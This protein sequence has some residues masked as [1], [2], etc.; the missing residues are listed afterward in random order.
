MLS[1]KL[2]KELSSITCRDVDVP[3]VELTEQDG[4]VAQLRPNLADNLGA[5]LLGHAGR[6]EL[7][8]LGV[9][10]NVLRE[11]VAHVGRLGGRCKRWLLLKQ[12]PG[13]GRVLHR[14]PVVAVDA[15]ERSVCEGGGGG[16]GARLDA[17]DHTQ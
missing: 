2:I 10:Q 8:V 14:L 1:S 11:I 6:L 12:L 17:M 9:D 7:N 3:F 16:H 4:L 13:E 5:H 15:R